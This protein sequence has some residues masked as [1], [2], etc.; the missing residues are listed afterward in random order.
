[1]YSLLVREMAEDLAGVYTTNGRE[2]EV[3]VVVRQRDAAEQVHIAT[4]TAAVEQ[5]HVNIRRMMS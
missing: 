1:M 3:G 5:N 2:P 4:E